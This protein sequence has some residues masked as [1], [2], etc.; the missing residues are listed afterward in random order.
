M[1][2]YHKYPEPWLSFATVARILEDKNRA[3]LVEQL[4][5]IGDGAEF[6]LP[7]DL[8][9]GLQNASNIQSLL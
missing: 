1:L 9:K 2:G 3:Q 5:L 6:A 7:C 4:F 8:E